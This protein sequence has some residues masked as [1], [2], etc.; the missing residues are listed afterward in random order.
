MNKMGFVDKLKGLFKKESDEAVPAAAPKA[1]APAAAP[2]AGGSTMQGSVY[3]ESCALQPI[4]GYVPNLGAPA[5]GKIK[6][7]LYWAAACGG[8]DV[9]VLDS[10]EKVLNIGDMADIVMWPVA[11]DGKEHD[12]EEMEDGSITVSIING[13]VRSSENEHMVKLLRKKSALVVGYGTCACFGGTPALA[14]L[15]AGGKDEILDYV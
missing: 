2:A 15:V 4:P 14:N 9:S 1:A 13:A 7:A 11:S 10:D 12:I 8:C 6:I 3:A 5:N